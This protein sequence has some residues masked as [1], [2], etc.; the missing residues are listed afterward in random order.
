MVLRSR[1]PKTANVNSVSASSPPVSISRVMSPSTLEPLSF[2]EAD[3]YLCWHTAMKDEIAALHANATWS[4]VPFDPSMNIVG[5]RWVYKIKR[6]ADGAINR[7]KARL[8][9]RGFTQQEG[10]DYSETFSH[11]VKSTTVRLVL[12]IAVSKGWQIRQLDVHNAFLNGSLREV[13]YMQQP[14]GF[15]NTVYLLMFVAFTNLSIV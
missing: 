11:V 2:K 13:V 9:A 14:S 1:Q 7:Y 6:R 12:T 8:V 10:I 5:C 15:V 4:L 3:Q